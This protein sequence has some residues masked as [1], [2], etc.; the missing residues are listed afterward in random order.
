MNSLTSS[1]RSAV[2]KVT[3]TSLAP[4]WACFTV[5]IAHVLVGLFFAYVGVKRSRWEH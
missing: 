1:F 5:L 4:V 2:D 3:E